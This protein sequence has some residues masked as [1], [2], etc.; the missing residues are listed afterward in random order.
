MRNEKLRLAPVQT[1][2]NQRRRD[3]DSSELDLAAKCHVEAV[4]CAKAGYVFA[5]CVVIGAAFE[6]VLLARAMAFED[7]LKSRERW[8][9]AKGSPAESEDQ[10]N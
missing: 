10:R 8:P 4:G 1:G 6:A 3:G 9:S 5:A 7:E 2:I